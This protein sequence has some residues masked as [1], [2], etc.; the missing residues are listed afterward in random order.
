[1]KLPQH[2]QLNLVLAIPKCLQIHDN[3]ISQTTFFYYAVTFIW[4]TCF[5]SFLNHL[6]SLLLRF[7]SLLPTLK[8][9]YGIPKS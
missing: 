8:M 1:M 9:H 7:E 2:N 6:Q 5:D 4:A 3:K